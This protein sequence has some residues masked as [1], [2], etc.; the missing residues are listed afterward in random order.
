MAKVFISDTY[1]TNIADAIRVKNNTNTTYTPAQM[2]TAINSLS[3]EQHLPV[4]VEI[5]Q[6]EH[7]TIKVV[8]TV[9]PITISENST[10]NFPTVSLS[11]TVTADEGYTPGTLNQSLVNAEWGDTVTFS[12]TEANATL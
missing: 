4:R 9:N 10:I 11:A 8:P 3:L 7:Q 6:S 12:A 1:L 2:V 5:I